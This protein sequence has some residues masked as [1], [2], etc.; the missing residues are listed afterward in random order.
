MSPNHPGFQKHHSLHCAITLSGP[1]TISDSGI[2]ALRPWPGKPAEAGPGGPDSS[3]PDSWKPL[4]SFIEGSTT[5]D[6]G[7]RAVRG[8]SFGSHRVSR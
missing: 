7:W 4:F 5:S 6:S 3:L 2:L 1:V 8:T